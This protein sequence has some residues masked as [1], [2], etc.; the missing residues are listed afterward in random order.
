[1]A[2][3]Q[4]GTSPVT[5]VYK[6]LPTAALQP[7][8]HTLDN[9]TLDSASSVVPAAELRGHL[10]TGKI[11]ALLDIYHIGT[12][13]YIDLLTD[14]STAPTFKRLPQI[15]RTAVLQ[16]NANAF[17]YTGFLAKLNTIKRYLHAKH[18]LLTHQ[19]YQALL[20]SANSI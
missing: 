1:M 3:T 9:T 8:H 19:N 7:T 12:I 20:Y 14:A 18:R 17:T 13:H 5:A 2:Y 15:M 10:K 4:A 6:L 11:P 16:N